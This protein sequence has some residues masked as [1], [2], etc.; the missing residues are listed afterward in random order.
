MTSEK[1]AET[2]AGGLGTE[3]TNVTTRS[4]ADVAMRKGQPEPKAGIPE[5]D[6][7]GW[8]GCSRR[9]DTAA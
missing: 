9:G 6:L 2:V 5:V 3:R 7:K 1:L 8:A 4:E